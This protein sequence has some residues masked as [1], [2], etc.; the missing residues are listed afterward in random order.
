[1]RNGFNYLHF[2][3]RKKALQSRSHP[4]PSLRAEKLPA[5]YR[6]QQKSRVQLANSQFARLRQPPPLVRPGQTCL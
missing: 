2:H 4:I 1:M 3:G 6:G 5:Q